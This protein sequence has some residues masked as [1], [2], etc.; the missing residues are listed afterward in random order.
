M[1]VGPVVVKKR[2]STDRL[3]EGPRAGSLMDMRGGAVDYTVY[4][5]IERT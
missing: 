1:P 4:E 3:M 2:G 5:A